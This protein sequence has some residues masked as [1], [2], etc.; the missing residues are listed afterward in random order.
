MGADLIWLLKS[1]YPLCKVQWE[2]HG[3]STTIKWFMSI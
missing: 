1:A 2:E 3:D